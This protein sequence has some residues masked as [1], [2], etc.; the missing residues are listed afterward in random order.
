MTRTL[1]ICAAAVLMLALIAIAPRAFSPGAL[2]ASRTSAQTDWAGVLK[3]ARGQTVRWWMYGGDPRINAYIN[4][5]I[6][7]A[8]ARLGV[9]L[10]VVPISDTADA[11]NRVVAERKAGKTSGGG[12]DLIWIN[13]ENFASGKSV[14]L[15]LQNWAGSLPDVKYVDQA[16]RLISRDFQVPVAG[17]ESPWSEAAFVYAYDSAKVSNPPQTFRAL[18]AWPKAHPGRFA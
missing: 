4:R 2:S 8:A 14:G 3:Q 18:L 17:Q 1:R 9:R 13:G 6:K 11:V 15:W 10:Q 5:F 16:S 7:P 12:V